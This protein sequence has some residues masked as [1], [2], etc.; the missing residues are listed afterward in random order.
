M[1][2]HNHFNPGLLTFGCAACVER[3]KHDQFIASL[4][5]MSAEEL[6][7]HGWQIDLRRW[8]PGGLTPRDKAK[9]RAISAELNGR[10]ERDEIA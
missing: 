5:H 7:E 8:R 4:P 9:D 2:K 6:F 1:T 3:V 10:R